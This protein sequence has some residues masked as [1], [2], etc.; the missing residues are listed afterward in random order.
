MANGP[1]GAEYRLNKEKDVL[2]VPCETVLRY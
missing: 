1:D 2:V